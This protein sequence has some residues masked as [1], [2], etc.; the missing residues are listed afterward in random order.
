MLYI[1]IV[2]AQ[3]SLQYKNDESSTFYSRKNL[4]IAFLSG[5]YASTLVSGY[6]MWWRDGQRRFTFYSSKEGEGWLNDPYSKGIDKVGHFY[7]SYFF[8]K[9]SKNLLI[10]GGY[11]EDDSKLH[12]AIMSLGIGLVIEV[13]D[14]F[15]RFGF[16]Y[17]DLVFNTIG[18]G[19]GYLQ[20]VLPVLQNFNFKWSYIP[21]H[22]FHFPPNLTSTYE[23]HIYWLTFDVHNLVQN[24]FMNFYPEYLQ[25]RIGYSVSDDYK[26]R[27]YL[28][29]LDFNLDK[30]FSTNNQD[31][32]LII[33]T[34]NLLHY[35]APGVK[36]S[37][38]RKPNYRF[39]IFN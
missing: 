7:T 5:A 29:G 31:W 8:Y 17:Q 13:G 16:D 24:T 3:D 34:A 20:D 15:S 33:D 1:Q 12:A 6:Y 10:W 37:S 9:L 18:L 30:I 4:S 35:P 21:T 36:F 26:R 32:K 2:F 39:F 14:G 25:L 23:A 19:Y 38:G 28:I 22:D 27:E 11:P